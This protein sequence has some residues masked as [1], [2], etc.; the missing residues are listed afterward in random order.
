[1]S[2]K[3]T[4][5]WLKKQEKTFLADRANRVAMD[6]VTAV[7]VNESA[8]RP[9]A[10]RTDLHAYSVSLPQKGITN[11]KRSGRFWMFAALNTMRFRII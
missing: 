4:K 9:D 11:Q 3:I 8:K 2:E 7:G 5:T 6:A 10:F 1:M